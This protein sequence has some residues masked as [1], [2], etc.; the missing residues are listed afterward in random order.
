MEACT[1]TLLA[2]V[3]L[4][5][6]SP[7]SVSV[8]LHSLSEKDYRQLNGLSLERKITLRLVQEGFAVVAPDN[9]NAQIRVRALRTA[10]GLSLEA[11]GPLN[12]LQGTVRLEGVSL[13]EAH[14][15]VVQKVAEL[16]RAIELPAPVAPAPPAVV[17]E[18]PAP[19]TEPIAPVP[20]A[21]APSRVF[22]E[23][24][25]GG[26]A[27]FRTDA[28]DPQLFFS[29]RL[30]FGESGRGFA[31]RLE[32]LGSGSKSSDIGVLQLSGA[33]ALGY[34]FGLGE[35][36][37]VEPGAGV[38]F[39]VQTYQ[40]SDPWAGQRSGTLISP[41]AWADVRAHLLLS[42]HLGLELRL[43][44]GFSSPTSHVDVGETLWRQGAIRGEAGLALTWAF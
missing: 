19:P 36:F 41:A 7:V 37:G 2:S 31:L 26:G 21:P 12:E 11:S 30:G 29:G 24:A 10:Y 38:G 18:P 42:D 39:V 27:S 1:L 23:L 13:A 8:D 17:A 4:A 34:R 32:L 3:L 40:L 14:L 20:A 5:Q 25:L 33:F 6:G 44:A 28:V 43:G 16:I 9:P 35:R 15:E 22:V